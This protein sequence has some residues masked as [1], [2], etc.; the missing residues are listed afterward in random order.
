MGLL[1]LELKAHPQNYRIFYTRTE[2]NTR[3]CVIV[4]K[5]VVIKVFN[6]VISC[7]RRSLTQLPCYVNCKLNP[8]VLIIS[9]L[10]IHLLVTHDTAPLTIQCVLI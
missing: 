3:R 4:I 2:Y 7:I 10:L 5:H 6:V 1:F 8:T 9:G